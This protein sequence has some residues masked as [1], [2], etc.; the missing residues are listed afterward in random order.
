MKI[1]FVKYF[2]VRFMNKRDSREEVK[3][4]RSKRGQDIRLL[5]IFETV[6]QIISKNNVNLILVALEWTYAQLLSNYRGRQY[7]SRYKRI[8]PTIIELQEDEQTYIN[9]MIKFPN[10]FL[11]PF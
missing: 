8:F 4:R 10:T 9:K 5:R 6:R 1:K 2:K 3:A 11:N 7:M